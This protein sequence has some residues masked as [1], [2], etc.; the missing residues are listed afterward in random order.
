MVNS[1]NSLIC[2]RWLP[3]SRARFAISSLANVS[4]LLTGINVNTINW[5]G[6]DRQFQDPY[7][8]TITGCSI[9]YSGSS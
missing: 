8:Q 6:C 2:L 4:V 9:D 3:G 1:I 5:D 7:I